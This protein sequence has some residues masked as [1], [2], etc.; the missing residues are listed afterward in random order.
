[1]QDT[2]V[3][4]RLNEFLGKAS[5]ATYAGGGAETTPEREG[6]REL[7]YHENDWQYRDSYAGFTRSW[8][9]ELV[10]YKGEPFW[11]ALY[12]GGMTSN[13]KDDAAFAHEA[14][15]FL[16]RALS[17]G[18]KV[19]AFQPRGP[20]NFSDGDWEYCC[21]WNDDITDFT[22]HEE[23]LYKNDVVFTH[24]VIGGLIISE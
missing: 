13:Y 6:Y 4:K 9:T 14:F 17:I 21:Q 11:N 24:N 22:A 23:I 3:L 1:M 15:A 16:K 8:G 19:Y 10:R 12:G 5:L 7:E 2:F 18:E 20:K